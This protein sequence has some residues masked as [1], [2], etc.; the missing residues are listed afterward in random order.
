MRWVAAYAVVMMGMAAPVWA[1]E[2]MPMDM[3]GYTALQLHEVGVMD[4]SFDAVIDRLSDG[5]KITLVS[6][7]PALKPLPISC[8]EMLFGYAEGGDGKPTRITLQGRVTIDHPEASV[9]AE[10]ADWDLVEGTLTFTGSPVITNASYP[11]GIEGEKVILN[12]TTRKFRIYGG[13]AESLPLNNKM[14]GGGGSEAAVAAGIGE[15]DVKDWPKFL[16]TIRTQAAATAPSPGKQI[17]T[18]LEPK[19]QKLVTTM[20]VDALLGDKPSLLKQIN[21]VLANPK[22]Y[23]ETAWAGIALDDAVKAQLAERG[24]EP[25]TSVNR[26]LLHAAYPDLVAAPKAAQ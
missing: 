10:K 5:V 25:A 15:N 13:R 24:N 26:A 11:K 4:V 7:D 12:F 2:P 6:D 14:A 9:R 16:E 18:L 19:V 3:G 17:V 21:K 8:Q 1:A 23:S 20:P 22:F